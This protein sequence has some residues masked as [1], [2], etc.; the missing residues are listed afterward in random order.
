MGFRLL[1]LLKKIHTCEGLGNVKRWLQL[2]LQ[3]ELLT[4]SNQ[5]QSRLST[6][7][8]DNGIQVPIANRDL[9]AHGL[10]NQVEALRLWR[11]DVNED[12]F[13][14]WDHQGAEFPVVQTE[15]VLNE[16]A[17][18]VFNQPGNGSLVKD[19]FNFVFGDRGLFVLPHPK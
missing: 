2:V 3:A 1:E 4:S 13:R 11:V 18:L 5:R 16:L 15:H 14:S 17:L 6:Q 12:N 10:G 19:G 9:R 8:S 7:D